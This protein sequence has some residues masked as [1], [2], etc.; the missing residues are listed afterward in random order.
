MD[1]DRYAMIAA[2]IS[3]QAD[4]EHC[5]V[6]IAHVC[7]ACM[8]V[9]GVDG[10]GF[11]TVGDLGIGEPVYA[12]DTVFERAVEVEITVGEGPGVQ[13]LDTGAEMLVSDLA[14]RRSRWLVPLL[15]ALGVRGVFA[16]PVATARETA[17]VL[18]LYRVRP[19]SLSPREAIDGRLIL[20]VIL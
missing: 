5:P 4:V 17:G 12:T 8:Q 13:A 19:R 15:L 11:C 6:G 3:R 10:A 18:E 7:R 9:V 2:A 20:S 14:S 16:I 1:G